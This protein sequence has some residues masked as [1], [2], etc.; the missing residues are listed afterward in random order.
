[1]RVMF[2]MTEPGVFLSVHSFRRAG[3]ESIESGGETS[4]FSSG[5]PAEIAASKKK[6]TGA[7]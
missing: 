1:M 4:V 7:H 2:R 6:K 5:G 3:V